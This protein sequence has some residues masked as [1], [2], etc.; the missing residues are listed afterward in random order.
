[1]ERSHEHPRGSVNDDFPGVNIQTEKSGPN[2]VEIAE[3]AKAVED[4]CLHCARWVGANGRY[5]QE[6]L[7]ASIDE[8]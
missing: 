7:I 8:G 4:Q 2:G 3:R 5:G 1:M 6:I